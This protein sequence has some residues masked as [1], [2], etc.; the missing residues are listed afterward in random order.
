MPTWITKIL[1]INFRTTLAGIT[2]LAAIAGAILAAWKA[3]D[4]QAIFDNLPLF[5]TALAVVA[6]ALGLMKAKDQNVTG[7]GV[8]AK[9]VDS[10][11]VVTNREGNV[12]GKQPV[13]Q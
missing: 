5:F 12:I 13:V 10:S 7:V 4:F 9:T 6:T 1:G 2:S 8:A 3:K 11:G